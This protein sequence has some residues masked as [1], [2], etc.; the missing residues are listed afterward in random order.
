M[1]KTYKILVNDGKSADIKPIRVEQGVGDK[2]VPVRMLAKEGW[3]I[4]LQDDAKGKGLAPNQ[5][6]LKRIGKDL[7]I[8]FDN[9]QRADVL[10]EDFYASPTNKPQLVGL[11]EN[12]GTY[13]YVPQDPAVSSMPSELKDDNKPV[14][15]SLGGAPVGDAFVLSGLPVAAAAGGGGTGWLVAGGA[16]AAAA[17]AGGGGGGGNT[18]PAA[19]S[20]ATGALAAESDTGHSSSDG[21][22]SNTKPFYTGKVEGIKDIAL[23]VD[24][25]TYLGTSQPD[26]VY[27]IQ[28][29]NPLSGNTYTPSIKVTDPSTKLSTTSDG[30]PFTVDTSGTPDANESAEVKI[31]KLSDDSGTKDG[32]FITSDNTL[33][34]EGSVTG[35]T[36]NGARVRLE[37][38]NSAGTVVKTEDVAF[39]DTGAWTWSDQ[40]TTRADG[41][42]TLVATMVDAAGN[43]IT[44]AKT[45]TSQAVLISANGLTAVDDVGTAREAGGLN[46]ATA[47][48]DA[49]GNVLNNDTTVD[50]A[51]TKKVVPIT[52]KAG[53]YGTLNLLDDGSYTYTVNNANATVNAL[54]DVNVSGATTL[55]DTFTYTATDITGQTKEATLVITIQGANDVPEYSGVTA[56][57]VLSSSTS[58][59]QLFDLNVTDPDG[60]GV[61]NKFS[62]PAVLTGK[63]GLFSFNVAN[64]TWAYQVDPTKV[65]VVDASSE[66]HDLL[67]VTS[68]DGSAYQTLDVQ[69][70]GGTGSSLPKIMNLLN[71]A[72]VTAEG[73]AT[74]N[75]SVK[76]L[77]SSEMFDLTNTATHISHVEKIDITGTGNNTIKLNLASLMQADADGGVHKLWIDGDAADVVQFAGYSSSAAT[78]IHPGDSGG[79]AGYNRYIFDAT[80]ELLINAAI[81]PLAV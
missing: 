67:T 5:V 41:K 57:T 38:K 16:G 71:V 7:A 46:N 62:V 6:R 47:G 39:A 33:N 21:I 53:T 50:A 12:G 42:Y 74:T 34:Y 45:S 31:T 66:F 81:A 13:E 23:T 75:D 73:H 79:V 10:V 2:G 30:T 28:I 35:F 64:Q 70:K 55:T 52:N 27:K 20:K 58:A 76:L 37:L 26:G 29:T 4:E 3:R 44:G 48:S 69:V 24:G 63:Y 22:T 78:V 36:A 54:R 19:P 59:T 11:A 17:A 8:Y 40:N 14:I 51:V 56:A 1:A 60:G 43:V 65:G 15:V 18:G 80:H 49:T 68:F 32:D 25:H 61:E 9:S 77:G 72:G